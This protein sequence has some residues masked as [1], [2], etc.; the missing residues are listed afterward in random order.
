[1]YINLKLPAGFRLVL[2]VDNLVIVEIKSVEALADV[3]YNQ[4]LTYFRMANKKLGL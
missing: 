4:V 1:M 3:H 2:M